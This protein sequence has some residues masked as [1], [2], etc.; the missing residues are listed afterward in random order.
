M[1][2]HRS[3]DP[4]WLP[5]CEENTFLSSQFTF[6]EFN[7]ALDSKKIQFSPG[8]NGLDYELLQRLP[9]NYKL[10]L[11]DIY[12]EM[13]RTSKYPEN[14]KSSYINF[15]KKG[16]GKGVRPISLGSCVCKLFETLVQNKLQY[17]VE[18]NDMI[19]KSQ[20]G[21]R[22]GQ[23]T[24]DNLVNLTLHIEESFTYKKDLLAAFLDVVRWTM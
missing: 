5:L 18:K 13:Y 3:Q 16:D 11:L 17:W 2:R 8:I 1:V 9:I 21:F 4:N 7:L 10:I 14:W 15:I 12:N 20:S 19:P 23:S 24:I 6:S 22:K